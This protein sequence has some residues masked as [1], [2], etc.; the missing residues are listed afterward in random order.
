MAGYL[1]TEAEEAFTKMSEDEFQVKYG[2]DKPKPPGS[3]LVFSCRVKNG[4]GIKVVTELH[5]F[6]FSEIR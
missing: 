5:K 4:P 3:N 1:D 2:F 6:G